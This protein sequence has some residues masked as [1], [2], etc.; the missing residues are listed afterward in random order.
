MTRAPTRIAILI[1]T[2]NGGQ[3]LA[4]QLAS[5]AHQTYAPTA[6]FVHDWASTDG[7]RSVIERFTADHAGQ[8]QMQLTTHDTAPGAS[9]SFIIALRHCLLSCADFDYLAF[10]DQD[11]LWVPDKLATYAGVIN[12]ADSAPSLLCSDVTLIDSEGR[13]M[14]ES[15]YGGPSAFQAPIDLRDASLLLVN[16]VIGMTLC[17]ARDVLESTESAL[18]G[19]WLMHDWALVLLAVSRGYQVAYVP[20][21]LVQYRQHASNV[22]GAASGWRLLPRLK[23]ATGHFARIRQQLASVCSTG[24]FPVAALAEGILRPG[25]MQRVHAARAAWSSGLLK[26]H[27]RWLLGCAILLMW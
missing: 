13:L 4:A 12:Q 22:L 15:F 6:V 19:Q 9:R 17:I 8:L 2:H 27:N 11:D 23:K 1:C 24:G 3:Y 25:P 14:A 21:A 26:S 18:D 7:T 5:L 10:C 16:P 20:K